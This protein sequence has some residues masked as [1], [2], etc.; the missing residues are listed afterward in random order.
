M[1]VNP[2]VVLS[3]DL[4]LSH[5]DLQGLGWGGH[6]YRLLRVFGVPFQAEGRMDFPSPVVMS[7]RQVAFKCILHRLSDASS[8]PEYP[9]DMSASIMKTSFSRCI[10][11]FGVSSSTVMF[12]FHMNFQVCVI[13]VLVVHGERI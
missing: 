10:S 8:S 6:R 13:Q 1:L 7:D 12:F 5:I 9:A 4:H 3:T 2:K 11:R